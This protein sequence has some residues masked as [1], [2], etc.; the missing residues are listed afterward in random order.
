MTALQLDRKCNGRCPRCGA[1]ADDTTL[2]DL[3]TAT[4]NE[5]AAASMQK[6][7]TELHA[8]GLCVDCEQPAPPSSR[9]GAPKW[10]CGCRVSVRILALVPA[11]AA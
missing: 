3:C 5:R 7:R 9:D 10:R 4:N 1:T 11:A 8:K 6:R 2:C